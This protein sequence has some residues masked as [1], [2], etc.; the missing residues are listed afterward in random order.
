[1]VLMNLFAG[2]EWKHRG[3]ERTCG[4]SVAGREW[5]EWTK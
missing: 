2:K 5:D 4:P 3:R 1:M